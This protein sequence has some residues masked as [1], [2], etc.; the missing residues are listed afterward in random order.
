MRKG[1]SK[2]KQQ[3]AAEVDNEEMGMRTMWRR[4]NSAAILAEIITIFFSGG[5]VRKIILGNIFIPLVKSRLFSSD[6]LLKSTK[7]VNKHKRFTTMNFL[8]SFRKIL[9]NDYISRI[10]PILFQMYF[11]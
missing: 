7:H 5:I 8:T 4:K 6:R 9:P 2:T 3:R 11:H 1:S 10:A